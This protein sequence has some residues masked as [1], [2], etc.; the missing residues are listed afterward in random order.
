M[1]LPGLAGWEVH[2]SEKDMPLFSPS[3]CSVPTGPPQTPVLL[4]L[5]KCRRP[6]T[7]CALRL[8]VFNFRPGGH[9]LSERKQSHPLALP[10][11]VDLL[12]QLL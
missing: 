11:P 12:L 5:N 4:H 2:A 10:R 3:I 9:P 6:K 8:L 1:A 7:K